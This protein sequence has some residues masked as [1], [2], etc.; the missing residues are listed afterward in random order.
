MSSYDYFNTTSMQ[1]YKRIS[2][3]LN[4]RSIIKEKYHFTFLNFFTTIKYRFLN[5]CF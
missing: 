5:I 2:L 1:Y 4:F 3:F